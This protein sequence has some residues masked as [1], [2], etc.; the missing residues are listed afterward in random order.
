HPP[1]KGPGPSCKVIAIGQDPDRVLRP[2]SGYP[3][4]VQIYG[5]AATNLQ[6]LTQIVRD[7][8]GHRRSG[9]YEERAARLRDNH[10]RLRDTAREEALTAKDA[11][12][13]DPRWLGYAL[14]EA[15]PADAVV[16][17]ELI[18]HSQVLDRYLERPRAKRYMRSFGGLGQGLPNAL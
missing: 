13:I 17:N 5:P 1:S 3:C 7:L 16:V 15:L 12:P 4:D 10:R 6:A 9:Q 11:T 8:Q 14:N 2:Y 18:V